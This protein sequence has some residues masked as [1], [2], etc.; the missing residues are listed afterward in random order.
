M[1][2]KDQILLESLYERILL[3]GK[4]VPLKNISEFSE[5]EKQ[6]IL[7]KLSDVERSQLGTAKGGKSAKNYMIA[8]DWIVIRDFHL[9]TRLKQTPETNTDLCAYTPGETLK[10][11]QHPIITKW[12]SMVEKFKIPE[13]K[14]KVI[15][16]SCA[17]SKRWGDNTKSEDY[18]CYN[19][20]R[21]E[22]SKIYWVT[23]SEPLG[24]VPEDHWDD[25]P[26]YDNPGL[27]TSQGQVESKFWTNQMGK[28]SSFAYPFDQSAFNECI[29]I[30]GN[31]IKKFYDFNKQI[32]PNLKFISAVETPSEKST[33]SRMLDHSG[34]LQK[35]ERYSKPH[36]KK[37]TKEM[38]MS[39]WQDISNK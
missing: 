12:F 10:L 29:K 31:V 22:N 39:H 24:I 37:S 6:N 34:I 21:K 2:N 1:K 8:D 26:L 36:A 28:Q 13:G 19:M 18:Q 11:L 3:E 32:N 5:E 33:H 30:L 16:V 7:G 9:R 35:E 4:R 15:F 25:F 20:I 17:A 14:E 23:I 38:R 27:F